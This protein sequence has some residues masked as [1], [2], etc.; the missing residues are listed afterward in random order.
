M[1]S[2]EILKEYFGVLEHYF[3]KLQHG[4]EA[5]PSL[6]G[7]IAALQ[8]EL[9]GSDIVVVTGSGKMSSVLYQVEHLLDDIHGFWETH[10]SA[11][12]TSIG[13]NDGFV[14]GTLRNPS[15]VPE[16]TPLAPC[17]LYFDH[18]L[19]SDPFLTSR[20]TLIRMSNNDRN[21]DITSF[22]HG[23]LASFAH[24]WPMRQYFVDAE[25]G[26][27]FLLYPAECFLQPGIGDERAVEGW[28]YATRLCE[29]LI[30]QEFA[31]DAERAAYLGSKSFEG[32]LKNRELAREIFGT[33][34]P[35]E[36]ATQSAHFARLHRLTT[37]DLE[38]L[39]DPSF[40]LLTMPFVKLRDIIILDREYAANWAEPLLPPEL[41]GAYKWLIGQQSRLTCRLQERDVPEE[42]V[43]SAMIQAKA[44]PWLSRIDFKTVMQ[45]R[46]QHSCSDLRDV[47]R[48]S[49]DTIRSSGPADLEK[50]V[51]E[52]ATEISPRLNEAAAEI[53]R[54]ITVM[55]KNRLKSIGSA[56]GGA[57]IGIASTLY[58][59]LA[60]P[61][62]LVSAVLGAKSVRDIIQ[63]ET[64]GRKG[65][66]E[67]RRR[68]LGLMLQIQDSLTQP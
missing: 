6:E 56:L 62:F 28:T 54:H 5:D 9:S 61:A 60:I 48:L 53:G 59:P 57:A 1:T 19:F 34:K 4:L 58:P 65:L 27:P 12:R 35:Q 47:F 10:A 45:L 18:T 23:I 16:A 66:K 20:D 21:F 32:L 41:W 26:A 17:G 42:H 49:R 3:P 29:E 15:T 38:N 68:P 25:A 30:G 33:G 50:I 46:R 7:Q 37:G 44:L 8:M 24:L 63:G 67:L 40:S 22:A 14:L 55:Q 13:L 39:S 52:A 11:Y 43:I 64:Q 31:D 36:I 51:A 2:V